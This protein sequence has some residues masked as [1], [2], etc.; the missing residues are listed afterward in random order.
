MH[1]VIVVGCNSILIMFV[2]MYGMS[3]DDNVPLKVKCDGKTNQKVNP[4]HSI[5]ISD[6]GLAESGLLWEV[7]VFVFVFFLF[8]KS[9]GGGCNA[10]RNLSFQDFKL[11]RN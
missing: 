5:I 1:L 7:N 4:I 3:A 9:D 2:M 6:F 10:I 8:C 11:L